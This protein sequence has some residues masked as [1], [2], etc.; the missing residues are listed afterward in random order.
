MDFKKAGNLIYI[1]GLTRN[2]LG[3]SHYY[4][5]H[6]EVGANVPKVEKNAKQ[7]MDALSSAMAAKLVRACHDC[8]EGGL[9]VAAAEMCF[10]GGL[11]ASIDA[12]RVPGADTM[13]DDMVMFSESNTRFICEIEPDKKAEF[14]K[15]LKGRPF[16]EIGRT[17]ATSRL[18]INGTGG[19]NR[20]DEDI[21][22]LKESWQAPLR[23]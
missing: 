9:A 5:I 10:A 17:V 19:K 22:S 3:G 20:I 1:V 8:S 14:E 16:A 11:G 6:G 15:A 4:R 23:W 2:E 13:R 21:C 7:I 12:T 18:V